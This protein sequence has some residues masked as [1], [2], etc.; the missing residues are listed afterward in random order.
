VL[1][2]DVQIGC[3]AVLNPGTLIGPR[4]M[5]YPGTV[6][7]KGYYAQDLMIKLRQAIETAPVRP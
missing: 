6:L 1:G 2:D 5:V 7:G 4:S 3:N